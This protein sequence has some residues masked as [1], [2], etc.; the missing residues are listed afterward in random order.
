[1]N[2]QPRTIDAQLNSTLPMAFF[3]C[4]LIKLFKGKNHKKLSFEMDERDH[5]MKEIKGIASELHTV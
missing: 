2:N 1:M 4:N 3:F 5:C